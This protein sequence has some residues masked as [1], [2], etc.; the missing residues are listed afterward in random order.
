MIIKE[1]VGGSQYLF[2]D[3]PN[4]S[5]G[6]LDITRYT[7][8]DIPYLHE[9]TEQGCIFTWGKDKKAVRKVVV[10]FP[11]Y[12]ASTVIVYKDFVTYYEFTYDEVVEVIDRLRPLFINHRYKY[13]IPLFDFIKEN[14]SWEFPKEVLDESY[15][16]YMSNKKKDK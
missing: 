9:Q 10:E 1:V 7:D 11:Y 3:Y 14:N 8:S 2:K 4:F 16:L 13:F 6:D 15:R 12:Y 5:P